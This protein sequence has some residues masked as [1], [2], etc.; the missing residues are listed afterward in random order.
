MGRWRLVIA[1]TLWSVSSTLPRKPPAICQV[2]DVAAFDTFTDR[3][4]S[5]VSPAVKPSD[6]RRWEPAGALAFRSLD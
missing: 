1:I 2:D 6:A 4:A 3:S 5:R